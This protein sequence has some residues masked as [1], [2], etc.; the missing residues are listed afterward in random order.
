MAAEPQSSTPQDHAAFRARIRALI[1]ADALRARRWLQIGLVLLI[2]SGCAQRG[3]WI[4]G[5]LVT[6]DTTGRWSGSV[7]GPGGG[8]FEMTLRQ[9]GAKVAGALKLAGGDATLLDGPV[10]GTIHGDVL[11]FG[12]P[13]GQLRGEAIVAGDEIS[14]TVTY[15]ASTRTLR[16]Q[17][18]PSVPESR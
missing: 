1:V 11:K 10:E 4:E 6:V 12:R 3:D 7:P 17:R 5:T 16:L 9:T 14:G 15:R 13:D 8:F 2:A 18:Q